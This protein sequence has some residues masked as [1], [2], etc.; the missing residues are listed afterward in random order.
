MSIGDNI[1]IS[2]DKIFVKAV[3]TIKSLTDLSKSNNLPRPSISE[4]LN[5]YGLYNQATKGDALPNT[6]IGNPSE[7][8]KY[9]SWVKFR[10]LTKQQA[11][12]E[13]VKYLLDIL[14]TNYS[15]TQYPEVSPLLSDL[16]SAWD[17]IEFIEM[18][19]LSIYSPPSSTQHVPN[20]PIRSQ[21]PAASL[22][23][24]ASS[25]INSAIVRPSSRNQSFSRSRQNSVSGQNMSSSVAAAS[26]PQYPS[27]AVVNSNSGSSNMNANSNVNLE[28]MRWQSDINNTLL[29]ISS[30]ISNLKLN[31][32][33]AG[34][35]SIS[36]STT[37][38]AQSEIQDYKLRINNMRSSTLNDRFSSYYKSDTDVPSSNEPKKNSMIKW[39][40]KKLLTLFYM[41]RN[42]VILRIPSDI[43]VLTR[44]A[45]TSIIGFFFLSLAKRL[46][47]KYLRS[48]GLQRGLVQHL[49]EW[50]VARLKSNASLGSF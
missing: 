45:I 18:Q 30:E 5:L 19:T 29:K 16:Q 42:K 22:Y 40:Y 3:S 48:Q 14:K 13:Y 8:K 47:Q 46:V 25:G 7:V 32:V 6:S 20:I 9:N 34:H 1:D 27:G 11:R 44:T 26:I 10:G 49:K 23:R 4:R 41:A 21:S 50:L 39:I 43:T 33:D 37:L 36:G 24:I 31:S 12:K 15:L 35:R 38:S 28:F 2:Y 17:K